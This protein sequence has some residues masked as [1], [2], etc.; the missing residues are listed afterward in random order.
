MKNN[1]IEINNTTDSGIF[2]IDFEKTYIKLMKLI[3]LFY[4][5]ENY[6]KS[7]QILAEA[8]KEVFGSLTM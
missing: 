3:V 8:R 2:K 5:D 1:I 4:N 6:E 7:F